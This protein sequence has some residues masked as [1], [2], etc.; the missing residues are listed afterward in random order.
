MSVP[1][2]RPTRA[3]RVLVVGLGSIGRRHLRVARELFADAEFAVLRSGVG[4]LGAD[5]DGVT[6]YHAIDE[7]LGFA[8]TIAVIASPATHHAGI[9]MRLAAAGVHLLVEK[10]LTDRL[11][12]ALAVRDAVAAAGVTA[13]VGYNLRHLASLVAL[14]DAVLAGGIGRV[15]SVRSEVGQYLPDWRPD[16]EYR[17]T[18][19]A[20]RE[21]GGGALLELSHELDYLLWLFG[22]VA[23]VTAM[24]SHLSDLEV[25]TEDTANLL[26]QF[27]PAGGALDGTPGVVAS[28]SLDYAR[29]DV[30]RRCTVIGTNGTLEWDGVRGTVRQFDAKTR[31][32]SVCCDA[33]SERDATYRAEWEDLYACIGTGRTPRANFDAGV[34]VLRVV[35]AARRSSESRRTVV[36][37]ADG[38]FVLTEE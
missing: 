30:V 4:S 9:A 11:E 35:D 26:L 15:M 34:A 3:L 12:T 27:A 19:S 38:H 25:D 18:V 21:L 17:T 24:L 37:V 7:A 16:T 36:L 22:D 31:E 2:S 14:R 20:R 5:V 10:P 23:S 6:T 1:P 29:R 13:A 8:P 33:P 32:W 28:V